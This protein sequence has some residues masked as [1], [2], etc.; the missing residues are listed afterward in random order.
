MKIYGKLIARARKIQ[1]E[2]HVV[3]WIGLW[4]SMKSK[5]D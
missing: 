1:T 3:L 4:K 5:L 2:V